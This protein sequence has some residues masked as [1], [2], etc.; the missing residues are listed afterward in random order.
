[1]YSKPLV[2]ASLLTLSLSITT[3]NILAD[4]EYQ[5]KAG[6]N[7]LR[8]WILGEV[9]Y[10]ADN[11]PNAARISLGK[12]LF[13]DPRLSGAGNMSC[14][15]C[16]NP[17]LGWSDGFPTAK[18]VKSMVLG[19]ASPTVINT[20]YNGLQMWDGRKRD[21][22]DQATGPMMADVEMNADFPKVVAWLNSN[23]GYRAAFNKA[24][25]D[26]AIDKVTFAKAIAS[27]ERTVISKQSPFDRWVA[28]DKKAMSEQQVRG[29]RLFVDEGKGNCASCHQAPNFTDDGFH[30]VGLA[31]FGNENPDMGRYGQKPVDSMKGAFKT[32]TLRDIEYT[33][34][35][36]HDGS[37]ETLA[38][39]VAH[40]VAGGKVKSNLSPSMKTLKL[41][42]KEQADLVEF[43]KALSSPRQVFTL[44]TLP[45]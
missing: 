15:T 28:G 35:Y 22:E 44:P 24:Y 23:K 40:Y 41:N 4:S 26:E 19:R 43:L 10:P 42:P 37:A 39:I 45:L 20:A 18:G 8:P 32:P 13:F 17:M 31:S 5:P 11:K 30:N 6:H 9:P 29:F 34:P 21:L 25:P 1:M 7:S 33:A 12:Q 16:H 36:F 14:A 2:V 27:F 38:D 3:Q